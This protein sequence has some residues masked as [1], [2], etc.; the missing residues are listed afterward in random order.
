MAR[1]R[2]WQLTP[3]DPYALP[4][5]ADARLRPTDYTDDQVWEV[6]LGAGESPAL[7]LQTNYGGRVGLASVIPL[8]LLDGRMIYETQ[9]YAKQP[10]IT[11][12]AP[13]YLR[14][15]ARLTPQLALLAEYWAIDSHT[16]GGRFT[17]SSA[18][19][20]PVQVRLDL[21]GHVGAQGKEQPLA[22]LPVTDKT[23]AL[24]LGRVGNLNPVLVLEGGTADLVDGDAVSPKI[25]KMVEIGPN[26]RGTLRWVHAGLPTARDSLAQAQYWLQ[27][28]WQPHLREVIRA[29]DAIPTIET[30]DSDLDATISRR[31]IM[32]SS[33]HS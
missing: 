32:N 19:A 29:A 3:S 5:A 17:L 4:L 6:S 27:Q 9:G 20:D 23:H 24:H 12:F 33:R 30:G 25:G 10:V 28:D 31:H 2:R 21:F 22:I 16:F 8:W 26:E 13:G 7:A 1:L 15:Q 11:A 14:A 18:L